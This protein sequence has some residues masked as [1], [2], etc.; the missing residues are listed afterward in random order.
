MPPRPAS[1]STGPVP[2]PAP[3]PPG[4]IS[5]P[6]T[7][8]PA[9]TSPPERERRRAAGRAGT[10][11]RAGGERSFRASRPLRVGPGPLQHDRRR[12]PAP[13]LAPR[14]GPLLLPVGPRRRRVAVAAEGQAGLVPPPGR[15]VLAEKGVVPPVCVCG[16]RGTERERQ[17]ERKER[18]REREREREEREGEKMKG[19]E[20]ARRA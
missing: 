19:R 6:T 3:P 10:S 5:N 11:C 12:P 15:A 20:E 13:G 1:G 7:S 16:E 2:P 4:Q 18:E 17:R 9:L 14:R 8:S